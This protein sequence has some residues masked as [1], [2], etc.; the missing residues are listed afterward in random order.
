MFVGVGKAVESCQAT[1]KKKKAGEFYVLLKLNKA[2][3]NDITMNNS[4][5]L[6]SSG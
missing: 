3:C 5:Y 6:Q 1:V 4:R 2:H